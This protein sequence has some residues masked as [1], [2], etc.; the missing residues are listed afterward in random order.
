MKFWNT[1]HI[2]GYQEK[3]VDFEPT[4]FQV[5]NSYKVTSLQNL[6]QC[7]GIKWTHSIKNFLPENNNID[8]LIS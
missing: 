1:K 4:N 8:K 7:V 2:I 3:H 5:D 6:N